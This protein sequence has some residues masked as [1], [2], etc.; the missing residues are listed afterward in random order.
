MYVFVNGEKFSNMRKNLAQGRMSSSSGPRLRSRSPRVHTGRCAICLED[1]DRGTPWVCLQCDIVAHLRC[2]PLDA[3]GV[4]HLPN[5][6]PQCRC[7]MAQ[8][9]TKA[10]EPV[11]TP[12]G[13]MCR[14]CCTP[15]SGSL[16]NRCAAPNKYCMAVW[17]PHHNVQR[18]PGCRLS[19]FAALRKRRE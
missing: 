3:N 16:M 14:V 18:C 13:A 19:L 8:I 15:I 6:C 12:Y 7:T 9:L 10:A 17:H 2:M 1:L 5:G 4:V 11:R